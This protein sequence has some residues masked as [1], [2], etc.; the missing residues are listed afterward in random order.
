MVYVVEISNSQY[1]VH[2]SITEILEALSKLEPTSREYRNGNYVYT[3]NGECLMVEIRTVPDENI[4][5]L[6]K[7]SLKDI[8]I[9]KLKKDA[10][11]MYKWYTTEKANS[12]KLQSQIDQLLQCVA[13]L[14]ENASKHEGGDTDAMVKI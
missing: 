9:E 10:D 4:I 8:E 12:A 7:A 1:L 3:P 6:D 14:K 2:G 5:F 11:Q 13:E